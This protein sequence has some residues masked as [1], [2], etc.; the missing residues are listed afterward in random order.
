MHGTG[1]CAR[2]SLVLACY[3]NLAVA[4][5][6]LAGPTAGRISILAL[7]RIGYAV[8]PSTRSEEEVL[9]RTSLRV[10]CYWLCTHRH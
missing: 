3:V 1:K 5:S 4:D 10:I 2:I 8:L 7:S 6:Q 9:G